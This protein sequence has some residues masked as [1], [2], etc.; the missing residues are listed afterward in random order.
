MA[1]V[2]LDYDDAYTTR[3]EARVASR[4]EHRGR[5]AVELE[6]TYFFPE[7]GGQEADRGSIGATA[8]T[9]VQVED[10]GR[11]WH[12]VEGAAPGALDADTHEASLDWTRRFDHMQQHTGQHILSAALLRVIEAPTLSS[13]L[14]EERSSIEVQRPD[15]D[16]RTIERVEAAANAVVWEDRAIERHWVDDEGITRFQ[17]RKPPQVSGRIRVVEIPD[18]DVSACGGTHTRRTGEVGVIKVVRWEKVRGNVRLEFLCGGRALADHAWRTEGMVEAARRRTL[19]D[20]ELLEHLERAAAERDQWKKR[21]EDLT[22]RVVEQEARDRVGTPPRPLA[23]FHAS[24]PREELRWF[25]LAALAAGAPWV[26]VAAGAPEPVV[27]AG[28]ARS[29]SLDLRELTPGLIERAGGRGG[30]GADLVQVAATDAGSAQRALEW[31][32]AAIAERTGVPC[33]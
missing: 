9:D 25:A 31:I 15:V 8:V 32:S 12:V 4:G 6:Q 14:G 1:S 17:L 13:H 28:R 27:I 22:K 16:W 24:R 7:S 23:G 2:R 30:G 21:A 11:V 33:P 10:G 29:G 5:P 19:K 26:A 18:W 20:R 3:F